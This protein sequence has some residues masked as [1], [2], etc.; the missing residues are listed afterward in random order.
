MTRLNLDKYLRETFKNPNI[1]KVGIILGVTILALAI[2]VF[3]YNLAYSQRIFPQTFIGGINLGGKTLTE[4]QQILKSETEKSKTSDLELKYTDKSWPIKKADLCV[5]YE[6]D[7]S[8]VI[9]WEIGRRG[10]LSQILVEQLKSVFGGNYQLVI[11]NYDENKLNEVVLAQAKEINK[12]EKDATIKIENL[13]PIIY[14]EETGQKL[15]FIFNKNQ[16]IQYLGS[17]N[18]EAVLELKVDTI[19]PK[20]T[21][22]AA[23]ATAEKTTTILAHEIILESDNK[24]YTL[25]PADFAS[26]LDFVGVPIAKVSANQK[27]NLKDN[28]K[29]EDTSG[30]VLIVETNKAKIEQYLQ[31]IGGEINQPAKDAKFAVQDGKVTAFQL[32]QTGYELDKDNAAKAVA[33]AIL[34]TEKTVKLPIKVTEPEVSSADPAK[35]G[36]IELIGEGHTSWNGSPANR[37]H[38]LTLGAEKIS[39]AF[40]KPGQEFSAVKTIG[41]IGP[42]A[43]FLP[44]L[45]IKNS[46]QVVPEYGGGLCQVSTTL[47]RAVLYS[48]LKITDRTPHS[49]RVSYYEPPVGMDAT[50]YD[51]APDFK[52]INDMKTPI[53]IWAVAGNNS[54]DFQ[55]YGTKDGRQI[56]ISDPVIGS[57]ISPPAAVYTESDSMEPGAIRQVERALSGAT[58]SFHYK[59]TAADGNVLEN[60]TFVSK[61]VALP[62]SYYVGPGY[63]APPPEEG[64]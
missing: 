6:P 12:E 15:D 26:F 60:E 36:I 46:T 56:D 9:A 4:A 47:F 3:I 43:G 59:V 31:G 35:N 24:S 25:K 1:K 41:E 61:Y 52:F 14:P 19:N 23:A 29:L 22:S 42:A 34:G 17:F 64:E 50:I 10:K 53:L 39:G 40:V 18:R 32:S 30:W 21:Q 37:I 54:L 57:Y 16:I 20:I 8:A 7:K 5:N 13:Q 63:Q 48:G 33:A 58:A 11:F 62:N 45:V 27:I 49:F 44:E 51:P 28:S 2:F 38:N 55:I